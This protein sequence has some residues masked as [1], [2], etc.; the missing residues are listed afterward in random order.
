MYN[1]KPRAQKSPVVKYLH[2][3]RDTLNNELK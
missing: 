2:V 1:L 3:T